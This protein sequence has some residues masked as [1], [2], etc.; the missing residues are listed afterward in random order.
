MENGKQINGVEWNGTTECN[1]MERNATDKWKWNG[2]M[3]WNG[4]NG[5]RM[6]RI[7][8]KTNGNGQVEKQMA[9]DKWKNEWQRISGKTNGNG[10]VEKRT[11]TDKWKNE[12]QRISGK[13]N[14][15]G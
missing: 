12:W 13:T 8:G 7:S 4:I 9:T 3:E 2:G 15:N 14:G 6:Q 5:K 1:G 10:K 11:A